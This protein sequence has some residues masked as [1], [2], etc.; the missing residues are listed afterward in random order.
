M[1]RGREGININT[2]VLLR[3]E[4]GQAPG[5]AEGPQDAVTCSLVTHMVPLRTRWRRTPGILRDGQRN[6]VSS[7][8]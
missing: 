5:G 8:D 7:S 2:A 1:G 4:S 6:W 3:A